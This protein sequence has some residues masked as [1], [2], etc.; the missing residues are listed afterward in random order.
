MEQKTS[1]LIVDDSESQFRTMSL[2][3]ERKGYDVSTAMNGP[4]AM[5]KVRE[6][7]FDL[8]FMDM[9]MPQMDGVET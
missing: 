7:P 9:K 4:D 3:L 2:I 6:T 8:I 1:I 5:E